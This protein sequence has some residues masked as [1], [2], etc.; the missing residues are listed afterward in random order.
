MKF[1]TPYR[2]FP[3]ESSAHRKLGAFNWPRAIKQ[4]ATSVTLACDCPTY[5]ITDVDTEVPGLAYQY[6]TEERRLMLWILEVSKCYLASRDFDADTVFLSPD[7]LVYGDLRRWF[8]GDLGILVRGRKFQERPILNGVQFWRPRAQQRLVAF[9]DAALQL[10]RTLPP[11]C[12]TWGADTEALKQ[13]LAPFSPGQVE[14]HGLTV[15]F[16]PA[17]RIMRTVTRYELA[18]LRH[19]H[20]IAPP[21]RPIIDFKYTRKAAMPAY[22]AAT[23]VRVSA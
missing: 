6:V 1:I 11:S 14:R 17:E 23:L 7:L 18:A 21:D 5:V 16:L 2:P 8:D 10:A 13:L 9:Y 3:P 20:T 15:D 4:M 22:Y 19:Q 12:I